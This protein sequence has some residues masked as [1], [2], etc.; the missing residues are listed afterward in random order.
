MKTITSIHICPPRQHGIIHQLPV[1]IAELAETLQENGFDLLAELRDKLIH[2]FDDKR[3]TAKNYESFL[4]LIILSPKIREVGG[5]VEST[6]ILVFST[7]ETLREVGKK[8]DIWE[9]Q[10]QNGSLGRVVFPDE[11]KRGDDLKIHL[12]NACFELT[13]ELAAGLNGFQNTDNLSIS[14]IGVGALGSQLVMN[15]ARAGF[16]KWVLIDHDLLMPHN[17]ARH[18]LN[19]WHLGVAKSRTVAHEANQ[20]SRNTNLFKSIPANILTPGPRADSVKDALRD[21][22]IILDMSAS[23]TVARHLARN[24]ESSARRIFFVSYPHR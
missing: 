6:D 2:W 3:L 14:A 9:A 15:L 8:L 17:L 11:S 18:S 7:E 10:P 1:T 23:V 24:I 19:V 13:R 4:L 5:E 22:V 20:I 12:F 16:G 21:C